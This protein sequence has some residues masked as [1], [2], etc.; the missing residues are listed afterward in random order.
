MIGPNRLLRNLRRSSSR[1]L[2]LEYLEERTLP[3]SVF[4]VPVT[5][6]VDATH[7]HSMADAAAA[8]GTNGAG[9]S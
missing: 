4:V 2:C 6:P 9:H 3:A 5:V 8:A 1:R 7:F